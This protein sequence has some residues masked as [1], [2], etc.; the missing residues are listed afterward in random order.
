[1]SLLLPSLATAIGVSVWLAVETACATSLRIPCLI[2]ATL[3]TGLVGFLGVQTLAASGR[4]SAARRQHLRAIRR[5]CRY[6]PILA[7]LTLLLLAGLVGIPLLFPA[8]ELRSSRSMAVLPRRTSSPHFR[9][10]TAARPETG[11]EEPDYLGDPVPDAPAANGP[12]AP[13]LAANAPAAP[14]PP[15]VDSLARDSAPE[16]SAAPPAA[17]PAAPAPGRLEQ[18]LAGSASSPSPEPP[19]ILPIVALEP[20]H[21]HL[22]ERDFG[23]PPDAG[24][25]YLPRQEREEEARGAPQENP[26]SFRPDPEDLG[27]WRPSELRLFGLLY[28]PLPDE[29]DRE[30]IPPPEARLEGLLLLGKDARVPGAALAIEIPFARNDLILAGFLGAIMP[31]P[32]NAD[33][34]NAPNWDHFT[35]AYTRRLT[36]WTSHATFDFSASVGV[37]ADHLR[38]VAGIPDPQGVKFAPYVGLDL[39]FWKE[40]AVGLLLHAGESLALTT[41][42]SSLGVTDVSALLRLDLTERISIHGGYRILL[43]KYK[44]DGLAS[45]AGVDVLHESLTGPIVG[46]DVRF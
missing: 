23:A 4:P 18:P 10:T 34:R 1:L 43:L 32:E 46:L 8:P 5:H 20:L 33:P 24:V 36:G 7:C 12:A 38:S 45:S 9:T 22:A 31:P 17:P 37:T 42:G 16:R 6:N 11:P 27:N 19:Q 30:G 26:F 13:A 28:R 35:A 3:L 39:G 15:K 21:L 29:W 25:P 41:F 2:V 40:N 44:S 14:A